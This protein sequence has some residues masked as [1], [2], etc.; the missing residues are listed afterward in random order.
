[1]LEWQVKY[2]MNTSAAHWNDM[3]WLETTAN[4]IDGYDSHR[5]HNKPT[6]DVE[7]PDVNMLTLYP[8]IA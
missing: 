3:E 4:S 8:F 7:T 6:M 1:M 5:N 2:W